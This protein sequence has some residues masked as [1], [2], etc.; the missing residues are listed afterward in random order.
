M[1]FCVCE[2][3]EDEEYVFWDTEDGL[4]QDQ[5]MKEKTTGKTLE[6]NR[7]QTNSLSAFTLAAL[8]R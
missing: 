7:G 5:E 4:D 3:D 8:F 1:R 2:E 6:S